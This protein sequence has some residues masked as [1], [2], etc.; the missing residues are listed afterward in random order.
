MEDCRVGRE[1]DRVDE[2]AERSAPSGVRPAASGI[3]AV[4]Q[5]VGN[6]GVSRL[7]ASPGGA[8]ALQRL[9]AAQALARWPWSKQPELLPDEPVEI[10][11]EVELDPTMFMP[12]MEAHAERERE[13]K[14]PPTPQT[15]EPGDHVWYYAHPD[16]DVPR[17]TADLD[18]PRD[19]WFPGS[20]GPTDYGGHGMEI[21]EF[22]IYETEVR[23]GWPHMKGKPGTTAWIN[24]NPGNLSGSKEDV[25]QYTGKANWHYFL[26]FPTYQ[27]G[28][29]AIPKWLKAYGYYSKGIL[30][31]MEA[32]APVRDGN[33]PGAYANGIVS[34]LKGEK[35]ADG[36]AITLDTTLDKLSEAQMHKVQD[37][38]VKAEG[39][40]AGVTHTRDD[41]NLPWE[42]RKRL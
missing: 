26:I 40:I 42:I 25:G 13:G 37:A 41:E 12:K 14:H 27:A 23:E 11:R 17:I 2:H 33:D 36:A 10:K 6:A 20:T 34:A 31:T 35:T 16:P 19:L 32:Y 24:N 7:L 1:R 3:G 29:D 15:F 4:Q 9:T 39:T 21:R 30:A 22:V 28:Y 5:A 8:R 38:I 18:V